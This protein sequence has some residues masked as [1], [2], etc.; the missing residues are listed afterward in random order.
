MDFEQY[1]APF[2]VRAQRAAQDI[3]EALSL[4]PVAPPQA[5]QPPP[6]G[7]PQPAPAPAGPRAPPPGSPG[8]TPS[9]MPAQRPAMSPL[10]AMPSFKSAPMA[11][12]LQ[13][14]AG[15]EGPIGF[16]AGGYVD[17]SVKG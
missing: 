2:Q 5:A 7:A 9:G 15:R 4:N 11:A 14:A 12:A 17:F 10:Q 8:L 13:G 3:A 6:V 1:L 16:A